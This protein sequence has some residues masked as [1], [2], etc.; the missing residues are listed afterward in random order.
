M[1]YQNHITVTCLSTQQSSQTYVTTMLSYEVMQ[2]GWANR[3]AE[4]LEACVIKNIFLA[5]KLQW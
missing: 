2:C 4:N 1:K 3:F 5:Q